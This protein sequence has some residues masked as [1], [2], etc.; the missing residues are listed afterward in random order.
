MVSKFDRHMR[1]Q[2]HFV[3]TVQNLVARPSGCSPA[4]APRS[5]PGPPPRRPVQDDAG[6]RHLARATTGW[7]GTS[8]SALCRAP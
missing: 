6:Q 7:A 3:A 4:E 8:V 1:G 2:V 5:I